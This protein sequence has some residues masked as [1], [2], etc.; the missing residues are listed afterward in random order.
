VEKKTSF[1]GASEPLSIAEA[2]SLS[3]RSAKVLVHLVN[4]TASAHS[5]LRSS[6]SDGNHFAAK[7]KQH[8][9]S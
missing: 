1:R 7:S 6:N 5:H 2:G 8:S 3:Q 9:S 4:S